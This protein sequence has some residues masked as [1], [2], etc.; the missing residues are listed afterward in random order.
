MRMAND[1]NEDAD[2][3]STAEAARLIGIKPSTL[4][5]WRHRQISDQPPF[6]KLNSQNLTYS[7]SE[8]LQWKKEHRVS[9]AS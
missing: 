8:V 2:E 6:Y 1:K 5:S 3:I 7:K 4:R 9:F